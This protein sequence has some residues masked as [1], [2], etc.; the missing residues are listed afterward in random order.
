MPCLHMRPQ[1]N[2]D[3][4]A[5]IV[6]TRSELPWL[7]DSVQIAHIFGKPVCVSPSIPKLICIF[8]DVRVHIHMHINSGYFMDLYRHI[9]LTWDING[10]YPESTLFFLV[11][12]D[13][14]IQMSHFCRRLHE[15]FHVG[16]GHAYGSMLISAC[17]PMNGGRMA[18]T[19]TEDL[20]AT[21]DSWGSLYDVPL[22]MTNIA[23]VC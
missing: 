1:K 8:N 19:L 3:D 9:E 12:S 17:F 2:T 22:V 5:A 23:M 16:S 6:P 10:I 21:V 18:G 14:C 13:K 15:S 7:Q 4:T 20:R 11:H